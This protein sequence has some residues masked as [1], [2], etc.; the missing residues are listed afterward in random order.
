LQWDEANLALTE[1]QKDSQMKITEP[2]TPYV[3]Y[4]AEL[5]EVEGGACPQPTRF[6]A[7]VAESRKFRRFDGKHPHPHRHPHPIADRAVVPT[8]SAFSTGKRPGRSSSGSSS[9]STSFSSPP[10]SARR[11]RGGKQRR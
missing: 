3:R 1:L 7:H 4:N 5:D 6:P 9:R 2:K 10:N 11:D 8:A